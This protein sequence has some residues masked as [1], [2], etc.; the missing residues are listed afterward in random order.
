M[1]CCDSISLYGSINVHGRPSDSKLLPIDY[2]RCCS[3]Q[4]NPPPI[5]DIRAQT[6]SRRN[7]VSEAARRLALFAGPERLVAAPMARRLYAVGEGVGLP[8][9]S[10]SAHRYSGRCPLRAGDN[11]ALSGLPCDVFD[12]DL[13][14]RRS[15]GRPSSVRPSGVLCESQRRL[16]SVYG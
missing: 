15:N 8:P 9:E 2:A 7:S 16:L 13:G 10:G 1:V 3:D 14:E 11:H 12:A 5:T 4:L 6:C